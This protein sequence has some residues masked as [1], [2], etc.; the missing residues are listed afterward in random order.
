MANSNGAVF[1]IYPKA[2]SSEHAFSAFKTGGFHDSD[3]SLLC[4]KDNRTRAK[5]SFR[6][7]GRLR[8]SRM[9]GKRQNGAHLVGWWKPI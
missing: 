1:G 8:P 9:L 7:P 3:I 5:G 4:Q 2:S 6:E